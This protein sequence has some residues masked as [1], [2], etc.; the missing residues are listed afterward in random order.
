MVRR[1]LSV[2]FWLGAAFAVAVLFAVHGMTETRAEASAG[3]CD[4]TGRVEGSWWLGDSFEV[5]RMMPSCWQVGVSQVGPD[6]HGN[7]LGWR[8]AFVDLGQDSLH[9]EAWGGAGPQPHWTAYGYGR[10]FGGTVGLIAE[11]NILRVNVG[12]ESGLLI[13]R[14]EWEADA[15]HASRHRVNHVS[16][17]STTGIAPYA[18]LTVRYGYV[19]AS[20]KRYFDLHANPRDSSGDEIG[21]SKWSVM[22]WQV[23]LSFPF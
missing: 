10:T 22:T 14:S 9:E 13:Y 5:E 12:I 16:P 17:P 19:F 1:F 21:P 18:G 20:G 2:D 23:G 3:R 11:R 6:W 15:Y 4:I 8:A 7:R